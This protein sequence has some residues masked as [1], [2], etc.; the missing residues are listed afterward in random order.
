MAATT[1]A[2]ADL[3][4]DDPDAQLAWF[5]PVQEAGYGFCRRCGSSLFWRDDQPEW[6][7]VCAGTL[8]PPTGLRTGAAW[9]A[10]EASDYHQRPNLP[11]RA[12]E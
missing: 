2:K 1:V 6:L 4:I 5:H 7:A 9:W 8:D 3:R 12:T 10:S 11:E